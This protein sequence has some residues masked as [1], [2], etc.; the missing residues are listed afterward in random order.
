MLAA[1]CHIN[2]PIHAKILALLKGFE[3]AFTLRQHTVAHNLAIYGSPHWGVCMCKKKNLTI[4][5][6]QQ[7]VI[8]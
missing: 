6:T 1:P 8:G 4:N 5:Q 3:L 2:S 7:N